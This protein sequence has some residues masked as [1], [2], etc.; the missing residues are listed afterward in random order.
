MVVVGIAAEGFADA[1]LA[2][3]TS[4]KQPMAVLRQIEVLFIFP[5]PSCGGPNPNRSAYSTCRAVLK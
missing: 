3:A 4:E 1:T 5:E 2:K